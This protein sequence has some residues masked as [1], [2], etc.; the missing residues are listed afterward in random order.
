[1]NDRNS[2][3]SRRTIGGQSVSHDSQV[4]GSNGPK[5]STNSRSDCREKSDTKYITYNTHVNRRVGYQE[6]NGSHGLPP[7]M[8]HSSHL[9][10]M[11]YN[12][13]QYYSMATNPYYGYPSRQPYYGFAAQT[14]YGS[15]HDPN[16][17][18]YSD[19]S[20]R[21][22]K[23]KQ[24]LT[25]DEIRRKVSKFRP[26][27]KTNDSNSR[28]NGFKFSIMSYNILSQNLLNE[29]KYLYHHCEPTHIEWPRRGHLIVNELLES[30]ADI[31][32]LQEVHSQHIRELIGPELQKY[33]YNFVYEKRT[34]NLMD[35]CV[36][37]YKENMFSLLKSTKLELK[38]KDLSALLDRD[39]IGLIVELRPKWL[40]SK[41]KLFVANTHLL[42]NP[43]RGDVKITQLRLLLAELDRLAL[44]S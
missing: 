22:E 30:N 18:N 34:G 26:F 41:S 6:Y 32:C 28:T 20:P 25:I 2:H 10:Y 33:G 1:M 36:I 31:L 24:T 37:A 39:H 15:S 44:I 5:T 40:K 35:G 43:K 11:G 4:S 27:I 21:S 16:C 9:R 23:C 12:S 8:A 3:T 13:E 14:A 7:I 19:P 17:H 38:R 42:Y 29:H